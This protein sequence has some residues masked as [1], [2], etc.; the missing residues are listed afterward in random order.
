ML[1]QDRTQH[2]R[3]RQ[4]ADAALFCFALALAY[5]GRA[6]F[7]F[8]DLPALEAFEHYLWLFPLVAL[9]GPTVLATQGFYAQP[10]L[11]PRL[12]V[13]LI[14][15]RSCAFVVLGL[16]LA[17]FLTR[18]QFARSVVLLVGGLGGIL[19]YARHEL[20]T[21]SRA[22]LSPRRVLWLGLPAENAQVRAALSGLEREALAH[23]GDFEPTAEN[24]PD[25]VSRLHTEAINAVV[26]SLA[27]LDRTT[28]APF[29][30]ACEREGIEV[31]L[32]PG[33]FLTSPYR[34]TLDA[35]AGEP[36]LHLRAQAA[37]P[38]ELA[39]KRVLDYVFAA[40]LLLPAAA[41]LLVLAAAI[42]LTSPG[43]VI[44]RQTRA[45]FNGHPF[46]ILK[47]RTMRHDA[48]A[49]LDPALAA[50]NQ[51]R[52]PAFKMAADPRLTP[53]GR[54]LRRHSLDELP[55]LW[56]VLRGEMSLVGPRPLPVAEIARIADF[57]QRRRLSVKPGMTG[58]WQV[59]GRNNLADFEDWIRLDLAYIDQW[60]LWLDL[61]IL[62]ATIPVTLLGRGSG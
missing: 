44:F 47:L 35:F 18:V 17:M 51:L 4:L 21:W 19:V 26:V 41:L 6:L 40:L 55:Q 9:L 38:A 11:T 39:L 23:A 61:K 60:S 15:L 16:V 20:S 27:G 22:F 1:T 62:F 5:Y 37:P 49:P 58:L 48:D 29:L 13:I 24:L 52:G 50:Q 12:G 53:I 7:P 59:S 34:L 25:F 2:A 54:H 28:L 56:N 10:R 42:K 33:L 30:D 43:P 8:L 32:R 3:L 46:V 36:V 31:V 14:V 57:A 45:G